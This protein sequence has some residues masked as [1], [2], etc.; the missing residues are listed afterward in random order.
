MTLL[1]EDRNNNY[2]EFVL[3]NYIIEELVMSEKQ[4]NCASKWPESEISS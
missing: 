4:T 1:R 3:V 2:T